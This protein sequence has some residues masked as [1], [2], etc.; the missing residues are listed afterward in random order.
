[1]KLFETCEK[2]FSE[3]IQA[4]KNLNELRDPWN[5]FS[6]LS[7]QK[8]TK[9]PGWREKGAKSE[10]TVAITTLS[11]MTCFPKKKSMRHAKK[12]KYDP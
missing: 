12:E 3:S 6:S 1:M 8:R 2:F 7:I 4:E 11:H 5:E 9:Y 10:S